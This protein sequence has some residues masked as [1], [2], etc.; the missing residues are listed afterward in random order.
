MEVVLSSENEKVSF[1]LRAR[2]EF[3]FLDFFLKTK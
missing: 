3:A 2:A 1:E